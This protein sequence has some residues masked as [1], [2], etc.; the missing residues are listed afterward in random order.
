MSKQRENVPIANRKSKGA[1]DHFL[2]RP[3]GAPRGLL[4]FY[5]LHRI[6]LGPTFGYEISQDIEDKTEGAWRPAPGSIYPM[7]KKLLDEGLIRASS[8]TKATSETSQR[9]YEIT[10]EGLRCLQ[11]GKKMFAS[12][13]QRWTAMRRIFMDLMDPLQVSNFFVEGSKDQFRTSQ[14]LIDSKISKLS[15]ADAEYTLREYALN[16]ERQLSWTKSRLEQFDKKLP[17]LDTVKQVR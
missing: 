3:Q 9:I 8:K 10:S 6:S 7:L 12:L 13:G 11:K 5:I 1:W 14:E 15:R 16:L 17:T 4:Q 2:Q